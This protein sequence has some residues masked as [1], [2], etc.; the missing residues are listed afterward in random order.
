MKQSTPVYRVRESREALLRRRR[1]NSENS[2]DRTANM[3][4][5]PFRRSSGSRASWR[6]SDSNSEASGS[7]QLRNRASDSGESL[8][9]TNRNASPGAPNADW[10]YSGT[11]RVTKNLCTGPSVRQAKFLEVSFLTR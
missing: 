10:K 6:A 9:P 1:V 5:H 7:R 8:P 11:N 4:Q 3:A 2:H